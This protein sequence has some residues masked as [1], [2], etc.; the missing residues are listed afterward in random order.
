M[1]ISSVTLTENK[2]IWLMYV[3]SF[4]NRCRCAYYEVVSNPEGCCKYQKNG[5]RETGT[6]TEVSRFMVQHAN[7]TTSYL[8][9]NVEFHHDDPALIHA[10]S[11]QGLYHKYNILL[12]PIL[13]AVPLGHFV[14][15]F[16]RERF[17]LIWGLARILRQM[18]MQEKYCGRDW[19]SNRG[20]QISSLAC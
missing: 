3:G 1:S 20:F 11:G 16:V 9:A 10:F 14:Y 15:I 12:E 2:L 17:H 7:H 19:R 4:F 8:P 6:R 18:Q 5:V 13:W